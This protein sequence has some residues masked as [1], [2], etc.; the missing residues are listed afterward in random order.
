MYLECLLLIRRNYYCV[1][2]TLLYVSEPDVGVLNVPDKLYL[3]VLIF[4]LFQVHISATV[5]IN[6]YINVLKIIDAQALILNKMKH[7]MF[8]Y[9]RLY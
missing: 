2:S 1:K 5:I 8:H 3:C 9:L 7:L 4:C 6:A